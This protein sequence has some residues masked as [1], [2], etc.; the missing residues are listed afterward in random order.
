MRT[1]SQ[2]IPPTDYLSQFLEIDEGPLYSLPDHSLISPQ[3]PPGRNL[4][5]FTL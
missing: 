5:Q 4:I 3:V 2:I 1:E